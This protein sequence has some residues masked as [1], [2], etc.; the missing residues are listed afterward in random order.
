MLCSPVAMMSLAMTKAF[1][2]V[3]LVLFFFF[4][5]FSPHYIVRTWLPPEDSDADG[6]PLR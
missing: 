2:F 4:S 5:F 3:F 6:C 1:P